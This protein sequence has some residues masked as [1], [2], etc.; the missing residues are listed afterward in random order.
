MS[1]DEVFELRLEKD[2]L[3]DALWAANDTQ[4]LEGPVP[5]QEDLGRAVVAA[6]REYV[7]QTNGL[8][9]L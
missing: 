3:N 8:Y 5:S 2:A 7:I 1:E 4:F 9:R 6:I